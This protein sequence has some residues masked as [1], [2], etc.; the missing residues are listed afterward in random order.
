MLI[1]FFIL[2]IFTKGEE[3]LFPFKTELVNLEKSKYI[4][5]IFNNKIY[6][7]IEIG[8]KKQKINLYLTMDSSYLVVSDYSINPSYYNK[9]ISNTYSNTSKFET[10]YFEFFT[11]GYY[12]K[13]DFYF[14]TSLNSTSKNK[15]HNIEFI[16]AFE[17]KDI[18]Y[19]SSGYLGL[20]LSEEK[21]INIFSSLK[22]SKIISKY[23]W[24]LKYTSDT[25]G[26][27]SIGQFPKEYIN[28]E[29]IRRAKAMECNSQS[30]T[31]SDTHLC[32]YLK[33][34]DIKFGDIK[35]NR[36]RIAKLSPELG[37]IIGTF[38][39]MIKIEENYFSKLNGKCEKK[40]SE[41]HYYYYECDKNTDLSSFKDL[42]FNHQEFIYNFTLTKDDLFKAYND[43]IYFLIIFYKFSSY[44]KNWELGKPFIKKYSFLFD[45]DSKIIY[46]Y[47]NYNNGNNKDGENSDQGKTN[48]VYFVI[49]G[50]LVLGVIIMIILVL[51]KL[52]YKTKKK[53]ANELKEDIEYNK[54]NETS[55]NNEEK[56]KDD[57]SLGI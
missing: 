19:I 9:N 53:K 11:K 51:V 26:Y 14:Q 25:E 23:L 33:F 16:H 2:V 35:V 15:F 1:I 28:E 56:K 18:N 43:K 44:G 24:N 37:I 13:E 3:L 40:L 10:F 38:E 47:D 39:Y 42:I 36:D 31:N 27:L 41:N 52:L 34:N 12:A 55:E 50:I 57:N 4:E 30:L 46:Y 5:S 45:T 17:Y 8:I 22:E 48:V 32:W 54:D 7:P 20:K 6:I 21:K 29:G 49:I